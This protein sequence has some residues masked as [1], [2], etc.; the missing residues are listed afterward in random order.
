MLTVLMQSV[1]A[2]ECFSLSDA[3]KTYGNLSEG[4]KNKI[5]SQ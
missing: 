4:E 2:K 3:F 5:H 1:Q